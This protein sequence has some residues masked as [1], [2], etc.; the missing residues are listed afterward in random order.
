MVLL[1]VP[2]LSGPKPEDTVDAFLSDWSKGD[3]RGA[4]NETDQPK[5]A[6]AAFTAN[7]NGLD[8]AKLDATRDSVEEDGDNATAKVRM[9]W[10][11]PGI[12]LFA[13]GTEV[14]LRKQDDKW[15]VRWAPTVVHPDLDRAS[16]LGTTR[17]PARRGAIRDRNGSALVTERP[18]VRVG[19]TAGKVKSPRTTAAAIDDVV[20]IDAGALVRA[21][22]G[23]GPEQF[24]PAITLREEDARPLEARLEAIPGVE[25]VAG[26]DQLAPTKE[27]GRAVLGAVGPATAEQLKGLGPGYAP[28]DEAGQWG[29]EAK[30]EKRLAGT[31][32]RK[33]VVRANGVP[34]DTLRTRRGRRGK[35][36]KTT[37]D[38]KV[39]QAAE[40]A[41]GKDKR[42]AALVAIQPSTGHLLA[43]ANRPVDSSYDRALE[44]RY[45]PGSTFKVVSTAALL[46][47]GLK[48]GETVDCP[49]TTNVGGRS[50]RNFEGSAAGPVP[51]SE[52]F[53]QSCNTAFVS[54]ADRLEPRDLTRAGRDYGLGRKPALELAAPA[55]GVP[56]PSDD[57]AQ[58]SMMIGQGRILTSPLSMAGVAATVAEG[59]WRAPRLVSTDPKSAADP[60]GSRE[61]ATLRTLMRKVVTEGTGTALAGVPGDPSGKSGTAEFGNENP[62]ETHAW[63]ISFRGDVAIAV[64]VEGGEAGGRVAAPIAA[65]FWTELGG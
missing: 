64:L 44:G 4:A 7:R 13:Y 18:V 53:A 42:N 48:V 62:P 25:L 40:D 17:E 60:P 34:I 23:A 46:R 45:P 21:I 49:K 11:V 26:T 51:F 63:F 36:L 22:R 33:V 2:A 38:R 29:L 24:V 28:G 20:D 9:E 65:K 30:Y 35:S 55:A 27:F 19:V 6:L 56:T 54:L 8:K 52:D 58:A 50:F 59:R 14:R 61:V 16:R 3:H 47:R 31:A 41:L 10:T 12:G 57:A 32:E 1:V 39:Q 43:V 5:A 37:L 15:K